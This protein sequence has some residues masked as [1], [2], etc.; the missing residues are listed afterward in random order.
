[1]LITIKN[2]V[3]NVDFI[4]KINGTFAF[5]VGDAIVLWREGE[6]VPYFI[7][8]QKGKGWYSFETLKKLVI[9]FLLEW[10]RTI[11]NDKPFPITINETPEEKKG[12]QVSS[13]QKENYLSGIPDW[14]R[15]KYKVWVACYGRQ[16]YNKGELLYYARRRFKKEG[17]EVVD[18]VKKYKDYC[19][20][21]HY[22]GEC[23]SPCVNPSGKSGVSLTTPIDLVDAII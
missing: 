23:N 8:I 2:K 15:N 16:T 20:K 7:S 17:E 18:I 10:K 5:E 1:M 22:R 12:P 4:K 19:Y 3:R 6:E 9:P 14:M 21:C 13:I 11:N